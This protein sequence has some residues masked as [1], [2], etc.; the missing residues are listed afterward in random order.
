M[1]YRAHCLL[2][3]IR[4]LTYM[5]P[6]ARVVA[7]EIKIAS[8]SFAPMTGVALELLMFG[9][10]VREILERFVGCPDRDRLGSLGRGDDG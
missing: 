7:G 1:A 3:G 6:D 9:N 4:E 2:L 8:S 5:T 10:T